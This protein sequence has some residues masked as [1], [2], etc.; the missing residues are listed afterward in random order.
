MDS[1]PGDPGVGALYE[2]WIHSSFKACKIAAILARLAPHVTV[3]D[4]LKH[5]EPEGLVGVPTLV[6]IHN[7]LSYVGSDALF[8]LVDLMAEDAP[9]SIMEQGAPHNQ[10]APVSTAGD[11]TAKMNEADDPASWAVSDKAEGNGDLCAELDEQRRLRG[12]NG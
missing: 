5:E 6:D 10:S 2:L 1:V 4:L 11:L 9:P 12:L 7:D 3:M 8:V